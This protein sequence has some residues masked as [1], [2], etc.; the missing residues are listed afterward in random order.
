MWSNQRQ[1]SIE[2]KE[3]SED[4]QDLRDLIEDRNEKTLAEI[5]KLEVAFALQKE[6]LVEIK[7]L[8]KLII[9]NRIRH[10]QKP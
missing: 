1:H 10:D 6:S 8:L 2:I 5:K 9:D 3:L 4:Q 7:T